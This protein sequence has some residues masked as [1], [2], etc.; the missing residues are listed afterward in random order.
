MY[1]LLCSIHDFDNIV[2]LNIQKRKLSAKVSSTKK[3][4][5]PTAYVLFSQAF[6]A[7]VKEKHPDAGFSEMSKLLGE[8]WQSQ[9]NEVKEVWIQ[10]ANSMKEIIANTVSAGVEDEELLFGSDDDEEKG[11]KEVEAEDEVVEE[12]NGNEENDNIENEHKEEAE[13]ESEP[14]V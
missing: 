1:F 4:Q 12:E 3:K 14:A 2:V 7:E 5:P 8:L 13:S 6:R 11:E 10:K 9:T